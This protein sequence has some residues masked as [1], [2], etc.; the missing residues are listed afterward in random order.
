MMI[1]DLH[2][3]QNGNL[4]LTACGETIRCWNTDTGKQWHTL[5]G[6]ENLNN[7]G[8]LKQQQQSE[9]AFVTNGM[10]NV[11]C[12]HDFSQVSLNNNDNDDNDDDDFDVMDCSTH[13]TTHE[14]TRKN[15]LSMFVLIFGD[16]G[17]KSNNSLISL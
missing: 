6:F 3:L 15:S 16:T 14:R 4:L 9:S 12:I 1:R 5:E 11:V 17:N 7:I 2:Y 13:H 8:I 10:K